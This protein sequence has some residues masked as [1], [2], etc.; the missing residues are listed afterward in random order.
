M[1]F[2]AQD[3]IKFGTS[4]IHDYKK[5]MIECIKN[6]LQHHWKPPRRS[7]QINDAEIEEFIAGALGDNIITAGPI[8]VGDVLGA[9][10][11]AHI[12]PE[13]WRV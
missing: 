9:R 8:F 1:V 6:Y 12:H 3:I 13:C 2:A 4:E 11:N 7:R 10:H 5:C